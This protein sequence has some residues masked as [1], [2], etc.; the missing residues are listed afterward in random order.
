M[1][2]DLRALGRRRTSVGVQAVA[3]VALVVVATAVWPHPAP[4]PAPAPSSTR[5]GQGP[6][7]HWVGA[8]DVMVRAPRSWADSQIGCE[9]DPQP[10]VV[11][12]AGYWTQCQ[13]TALGRQRKPAALWVL[14]TQEAVHGYGGSAYAK[15]DEPVAGLD[16]R[17]SPVFGEG[18][19]TGRYWYQALVVP[20]AHTMFVAQS[21]SRQQVV[22]I[23]ATARRLPPGSVAPRWTAGE[24]LTSAR[25]HLRGYDV[26]ARRERSYYRAGTV[27][28][29]A[30][31]FGTP[32]RPGAAVTLTVSDGLGGRHALSDALLARQGIRVEPLGTVTPA[33]RLRAQAAR[34]GI[35]ARLRRAGSPFASQLVL[36]RITSTDY[37]THNGPVLDHR[38]VWLLLAPHVLV[39]SLGGPC[40]HHPPPPAGVGRDVSVYD[41]LTGRNVWGISF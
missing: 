17:R 22:S 34:E 5:S 36:R 28:G 14:T 39:S 8:G 11:Y 10:S 23:I 13:D 24:D 18:G 6:E 27:I 25:H 29:S 20:S 26:T 21:A 33:E 19:D 30:P 12:D 4:G 3:A 7:G 37:R 15:A 40:C 38:L 1:T 9:T 41:A 32:L 35:E 2:L 31:A 16:A